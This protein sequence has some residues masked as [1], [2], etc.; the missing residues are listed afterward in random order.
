M[1][2]LIQK[3]KFPSNL[4]GWAGHRSGGVRRMFDPGSG[5]PTGVVVRTA[6]IARLERWAEQVREGTQF[7]ATLLLVGGPGNGKTEAVESTLHYLDTVFELD[8]ALLATLARELSPAPGF[9]VP[10]LVPVEVPTRHDR[11]VSVAVVQD[12]SLKDDARPGKT[13]AELFLEE[14]KLFADGSAGLYIACVNRGILDDALI[15]ATDSDQ[16]ETRSLLET[17]T[18]AV[19]LTPDAPSCWP[20]EGFPNVAVWPMDV[21]SLFVADGAGQSAASAVLDLA[22]DSNDWPRFGECAAGVR[23]PFC[24][25]RRALAKGS[26]TRDSV[27]SILRFHELASGKRWTF[28]DLFSLVPQLL[29]A[30][31]VDTGAT[32]LDPC[33][34]AAKLLDIDRGELPVRNERTRSS[35]IFQVA[36][37]HFSQLLFSEWDR[38]VLRRMRADAKELGVDGD[39]T[40]Q[41]LCEFLRGAQR[42]SVPAT[43]RPL[44]E[45]VCAILDPALASPLLELRIS[46]TRTL[47]L[48]DLDARFSHSVE[49]GLEF[50]THL[51]CLTPLDRELLWRIADLEKRITEAGSRNSRYMVTAIRFQHLLRDFACR[52]ARRS[53]GSEHCAVRDQEV[54]ATFQSIV[55]SPDVKEAQVY[56]AAKK[57]ETLLN[58]DRYFEISLNTTFGE[59]LPPATRRVT[60]IA[61]KQRVKPRVVQTEGRPKSPLIFLTLGSERRAQPIPLTYDLYRAVVDLNQGLVP[62]SLPAAVVALLDSNRARLAGALVGDAQVLEAARIRIGTAREEIA[63]GPRGFVV[64]AGDEL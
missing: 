52:W 58:G 25:G 64:V 48:G 54:L 14:L 38:S 62:A 39:R 59:P 7:P 24:N 46:R 47:S 15:W 53:L 40:F 63:I 4:I 29:A 17:I 12:A 26:S 5:R 45:S 11:K 19:A 35:A 42:P 50:L 31:P 20:L 27:L 2:E 6:L 28:R 30:V 16:V 49:S 44:L 22:T 37:A 51:K 21:E 36:G 32:T 33:E 56:E 13:P 3:T 18:K 60:L 10:R 9:A 61:E 34:W 8:G 55:D 23:C 1:L 57:V 43:L 41:G